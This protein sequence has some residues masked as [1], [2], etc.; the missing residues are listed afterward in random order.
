MSSI[1]AQL[2]AALPAYRAAIESEEAAGMRQLLEALNPGVVGWKAVGSQRARLP[3][4]R[5]TS[6][7]LP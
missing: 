7:L 4:P 2:V 1:A 5:Q 3:H 6:P